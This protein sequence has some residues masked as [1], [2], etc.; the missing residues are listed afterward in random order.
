MKHWNIYPIFIEKHLRLHYGSP[1]STKRPPNEQD[2]G[3]D[4]ASLPWSHYSWAECN[5][6]DFQRQLIWLWLHSGWVLFSPELRPD[7]VHC[8][9]SSPLGKARRTSWSFSVRGYD[10][11]HSWGKL[12]YITKLS[13]R[14]L[15][16]DTYCILIL[17][18][19][20]WAMRWKESARRRWR[21]PEV[22]LQ[23]SSWSWTTSQALQAYYTC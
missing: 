8:W 2:L 14:A 1:Y 6:L 3:L 19:R 16:Y 21:A 15:K 11:H 9:S 18:H 5:P 22:L 20:T 23:F 10:D 12:V 4:D 17:K 7:Q 13:L